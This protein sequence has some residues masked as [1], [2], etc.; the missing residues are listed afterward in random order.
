MCQVCSTVNQLSILFWIPLHHRLLQ[1]VEHSALCDTVGPCWLSV[2]IIAAVYVHP[3]RLIFLPA[4]LLVVVSLFSMSVG[5]FLLYIFFF[6]F[7]FLDS[8]CK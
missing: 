5:L 1:N 3:K 8:T 4:F 6:F 7:F 2:S